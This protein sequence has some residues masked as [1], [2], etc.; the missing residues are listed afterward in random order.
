MPIE[1]YR[2]ASEMPRVPRSPPEELVER[3]AA[4]WELAHLRAGPDIPRGVTKFRSISEAQRAR[5]ERI[6]KRLRA[7][8]LA[9]EAP[10]DPQA[11]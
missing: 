4:A 6:Q 7:L 11:S 5:A 9:A 1:R 10:N 8:R 3:I 2:D